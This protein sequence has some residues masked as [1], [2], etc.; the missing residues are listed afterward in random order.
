MLA[1]AAQGLGAQVGIFGG[2][3]IGWDLAKK[4]AARIRN[5]NGGNC[6]DTDKSLCYKHTAAIAALQERVAGNGR[7]L[8]RIEGKV[9]RLLETKR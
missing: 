1:E 9:D 7:A 4:A 6:H 5:G 8:E 3:L 2:L